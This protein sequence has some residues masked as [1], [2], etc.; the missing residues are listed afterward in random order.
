VPPLQVETTRKFQGQLSA[1]NT[2]SD[3]KITFI[4]LGNLAKEKAKLAC[5][6]PFLTQWGRAGAAHLF[7]SPQTLE[8]GEWLVAR[9]GHI[10]F[11]G[12]PVPIVQEAGWVPEPVCTQ[13]VEVK[14]S[15]SV[16]DRTPAVQSVASHYTDWTTRLTPT[17][18]HYYVGVK[19]N[20]IQVWF[21]VL[22]AMCLKMAVFWV[23]VPCRLVELFRCFKGPYHLHRQTC[24]CTRGKW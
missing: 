13:T 20:F 17:Y 8:G 19:S 21:E 16:R 10:Y 22:T 2:R 5:Y 3:N 6:S 1:S 4:S 15:A 18:M 11:R 7:L 23:V 14:S 12:S 24:E 9:P